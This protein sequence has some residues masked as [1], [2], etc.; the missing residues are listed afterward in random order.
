ML[1]QI[2]LKYCASYLEANK[3][4]SSHGF[5]LSCLPLFF[6]STCIMDQGKK[7][8]SHSSNKISKSSNAQGTK[9]K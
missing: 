8:K 6:N 3:I 2:S 5:F 4:K 1:S 7:N 9:K